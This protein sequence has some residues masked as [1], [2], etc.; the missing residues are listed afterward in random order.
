MK[1]TTTM[2]VNLS[3]RK[4][5]ETL[6]SLRSI[7]SAFDRCIQACVG[8]RNELFI[9]AM[10]HCKT[11]KDKERA[12]MKFCM[13]HGGTWPYD[14]FRQWEYRIDD[15]GEECLVLAPILKAKDIMDQSYI[16]N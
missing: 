10:R 12:I 1:R 15:E 14:D 7:V 13:V 11:F 4:R 9:M 3:D 16:A 5:A 6:E 2:D 8:V